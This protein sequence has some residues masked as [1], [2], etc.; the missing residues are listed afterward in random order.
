M[1][2]TITIQISGD[3]ADKD[4][5]RL[6]SLIEQLDAL[7][8]ALAFAEREVADDQ[9]GAIYYRV[10]KLQQRSP[11]TLTVEPVAVNAQ[12]DP[13]NI[14]VH[15]FSRRL[16][17]IRTGKV[18][19]DVSVEELQ[20]YQELAPSKERHIREVTI[21]VDA[22]AVLKKPATLIMTDRFAQRIADLIGEDELTWGSVTGRLE[23]VNIH[24]TN[25][26]FIYPEIGPER[27]TCFFDRTM[28][29]QVARALGHYVQLNGKLHYKKRAQFTYLMTDAFSIDILDDDQT[30][31]TLTEM[32]GVAPDIMGGMDTRDFVDA[33][34]EEW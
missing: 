2:P 13:T 16:N 20:A 5:P 4:R 29:D 14:V 33:L 30:P 32:R 15:R 25:R 26:I 1:A 24:E 18:P 28:R 31:P 21:R 10:V 34:D 27:V 11:A 7:K 6:N 12:R 22:P 9:R 8:K 23:G 19:R 3:R 17:Q